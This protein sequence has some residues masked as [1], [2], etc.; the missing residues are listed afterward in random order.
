[1]RTCEHGCNGCDVCT[2]YSDATS[3][4]Q[5]QEYLQRHP[6]YELSLWMDWVQT[7]CSWRKI[8]PP[9]GPEWDRLTAKWRHG[10]APA[11]SVDELQALRAA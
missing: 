7:V 6:A 8:A 3:D 10:K 1:M 4:E 9:S 2:D 11:D 5:D